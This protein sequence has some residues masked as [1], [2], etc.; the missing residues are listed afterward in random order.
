MCFAEGFHKE[1]VDGRGDISGDRRGDS[2]GNSREADDSVSESEGIVGI[3]GME[4]AARGGMVYTCEI[5]DRAADIAE[6]FFA[7]SKYSTHIQLERIRAADMIASARKRHIRFDIVFIDADKKQYKSYIDQLIGSTSISD[8]SSESCSESS[9]DSDSSETECLLHA[10]AML[11][12]DN[13]LW[14]GLVLGNVDTLSQ[15]APEPE[16]FGN[17]KR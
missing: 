8:S 16:D 2:R 5:D 14:K 13:T 6:R 3:G 15:Y 11:I 12:V 10:N 7:Q 9:S 1:S 4:K 17:A